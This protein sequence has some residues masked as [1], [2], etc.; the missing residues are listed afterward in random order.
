MHAANIVFT[1]FIVLTI[2]PIAYRYISK[3][4]V[5]KK[6]N[7]LHSLWRALITLLL[8]SG[9]VVSFIVSLYNFTINYQ[10]PL[11][12][13][14]VNTVILDAVSKK[15]D[16]GQ[17]VNELSQ[18]KLVAGI[19]NLSKEIPTDISFLSSHVKVSLSDRIYN[20][21]GK[22]AIYA[23]YEDNGQTVYLKYQLFQEGN[24]WKLAGLNI[25]TQEQISKIDSNM[26]FYLI[27]S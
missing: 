18:N 13:E 15:Q 10:A 25:V 24:K 2:I 4:F 17:L 5:A 3:I 22:N 16:S 23:L 11:V 9:I 6:Q 12:A 27:K 20:D 19:F 1:V 26:K 14:R 7:N 8:I 21:N